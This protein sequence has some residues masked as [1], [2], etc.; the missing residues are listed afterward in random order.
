MNF[1]VSKYYFLVGVQR[2]MMKMKKRRKKT[3]MKKMKKMSMKMSLRLQNLHKLM[4]KKRKM[5][6]LTENKTF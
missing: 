5:I 4:W 2:K 6:M 3:K 1:D